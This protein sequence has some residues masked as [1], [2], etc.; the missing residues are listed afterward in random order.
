MLP[1][2]SLS[3]F[4]LCAWFA[5]LLPVL[6]AADAHAQILRASPSLVIK[7]GDHA[8]GSDSAYDPANR[9]YLVVMANENNVVA[10]YGELI[11]RFVDTAGT[12]L[13]SQFV[14]QS[15]RMNLPRV[16]YNADI[17]GG[18]FIV[19]WADDDTI[20]ARTVV[21]PGVVSP[22]RLTLGSGY[23]VHEVA[24]SNTSRVFGVAWTNYW[25]PSTTRFARLLMPGGSVATTTLLTTGDAGRSW[26]LW[27]SLTDIAWHATRNE[28]GILYAKRASPWEL[29]FA[30][31]STGGVV[32]DE[33][34]IA[35]VDDEPLAGQLAFSPS[36][37]NYIALWADRVTGRITGTELLH[38][39]TAVATGELP[40]SILGGQLG[41]AVDYNP[42][43][44]TF[45]LVGFGSV[46][47]AREQIRGLELNRHGAP[48]SSVI[49]VTGASLNGNFYAPRVA[50]RTDAAEWLVDAETAGGLHYAQIV[51][52]GTVAGG[53]SLR[54]GGCVGP[55]PFESIGGGLCNDGGWL[56]RPGSSTPEPPPPTGGCSTPDPFASLGGGTCV[57]GGWL[58]PSAPSEPPTTPEP[59]PS[60]PP[61]DGGCATPDPF[62]TLGGGTCVNGGWL[63]PG[64]TPPTA[65]PP[66]TSPPPA[67]PPVEGCTTPDPFVAL[68]G[69]TCHNGGWLPPGMTPPV[70]AP[71]SPLPPPPPV[72]GGGC[73]TPDPF[74]G[75]PNLV[76][77]C[78]NG[79]WVPVVVGTSS[80]S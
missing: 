31:V 76:G 73:T 69:G 64:A 7:T 74:A 12:P 46:P 40:A 78:I 32:L 9:V 36:T 51:S 34:V 24:Y 43:S 35:T 44:D 52:S 2:P 14:I 23:G 65:P 62:V 54:L 3:R 6:G 68:G 70:D 47:V 71:P 77:Q 18:A 59:P 42:V 19:S 15:G 37:G 13:G 48:V 75:I 53:S 17:G 66:P 58:P 61:G 49:E 38:D 20:H 56:P 39:G 1:T 27:N 29:R 8:F 41:M 63:P 72:T 33:R 21:Y 57:N 79:G 30:R 28:F 60:A 26:V 4:L 67:P 5:G 80:G 10:P 16:I 50:G 25:A 22:S 11:G 45:L 55:D